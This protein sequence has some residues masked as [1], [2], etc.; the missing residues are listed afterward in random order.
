MLSI[1]GR[2]GLPT[3]IQSDN[4]T[5]YANE[6]IEHFLK[7]L[8]ISQRF[9]LP[10][11]P[12]ANGLVERPNQE[13]MRHLRA[14]VLDKRISAS[15]STYLP[16]IQRIMVYSVHSTIGTYPANLLYGNMVTPQRGLLTEWKSTN[17]ISSLTHND[18]VD[19]LHKQLTDIISASQAYQREIVNKR[20]SNQPTN[21]TTY[22][23]GD[24][25]LV[26]YPNRP[27]NKLTS[28]WKGPLLV[29]SISSQ[30]YACKDLISN[31]SNTYFVDRLKLYDSTS[32]DY[33]PE[34]IALVDND[35][36]IV[37]SIVDHRGNPNKKSSMYFKVR[38]HGYDPSDD[39][40]EQFKELRNCIQL[41]EYLV[42][43]PKLNKLLN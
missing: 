1:F 2:F 42:S 29:T 31:K 38:W 11:R 12:Q 9:T 17:P 3:E 30:N 25:V 23:V 33:T 18:Y 8:A 6:T 26:S 19:N 16:L 34:A 32:T 36:F 35:S 20:L 13:I 37:E 4:G 43:K 14:I 10:Y 28:Q 27:P 39:T 7:F 40:W 15:W 41:R 22:S 24:Y 21:P 5:Q